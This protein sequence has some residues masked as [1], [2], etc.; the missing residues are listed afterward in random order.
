MKFIQELV[1]P[2]TKR[3]LRGYLGVTG[4]CR[5]WVPTYS[6][7]V[8]P[9]YAMITADAPEPLKWEKHEREAFG[10]LKRA[11]A[12]SPILGLPDYEKTFTL[13]VHERAGIA[14]GVLT[15]KLGT[16]ERPVGYFSKQ[17]DIV[18]KGYPRCIR[19]VAVTALLLE[20]AQKI[21]MGHPVT[22]KA[23]H[24]VH[25]V[26]TQKAARYLT[27]ARM[28]FY[29]ASLIGNPEVTIEVCQTLNPA[30]LLPE[31]GK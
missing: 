14:S 25:A 20:E 31:L 17:L 24:E 6:E 12:K 22:V 18:A 10:E 28:T 5:P 16:A 19:A 26:L 30:T 9:L 21:V 4:Y 23:P 13:F 7:L 27:P 8:K 11:I 1:L 29:E 3:G 2:Q 15:Q